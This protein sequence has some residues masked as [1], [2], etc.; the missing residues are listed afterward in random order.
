[1]ASAAPGQFAMLL[2]GGG[3]YL[4]R[5]FSF[6]DADRA[7]G[8]STFMYR[9]SGEGTLALSR[10]KPGD[11][12]DIMGPL[13]NGFKVLQS[14]AAVVGGGIGV[15]PM[16]LLLRRLK[17]AG[18]E[19]DVFAG[20]SNKD[21]VVLQR[22][23]SAMSNNFYLTSD[24]GSVGSKGFITEMLSE[25]LDNGAKYDVLYACGPEPM[26]KALKHIRG[27]NGIDAQFSLEQRMGCGIGACLVCACAIEPE[28]GPEG[29]ISYARVCKDG[30]VFD[31][32]KWNI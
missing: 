9:L 28:N 32:G 6:C 15:F 27:D 21:S 3:A 8:T 22:E 29:A 14:R 13:G 23:M 30:P 16:L 10:K 11:A 19:T 24:D 5:P 31:A 17:E 18:A 26:L 7:A 20:Y 1:M 2:C 4:R 12:L 25:A